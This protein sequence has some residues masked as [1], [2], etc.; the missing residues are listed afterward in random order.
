MATDKHQ[1]QWSAQFAVA[2]EL[3]K[4]GYK[5]ALT[6]GN[7]PS[8][9][10]MVRSPHGRRFA[11][12]VKGQVGESFWQIKSKKASRDLYYILA[13]VPQ[14]KPNKFFILSQSNLEEEGRKFRSKRVRQRRREGHSTESVGVRRG[15][16]WNAAS[17]YAS[18]TVLPK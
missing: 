6:L 7:H 14:D 16:P 4:R 11:I 12:D 18:W 9:D 8:E 5:I 2:S 3:C 17:K 10:L 15:I 13:Y 1:T